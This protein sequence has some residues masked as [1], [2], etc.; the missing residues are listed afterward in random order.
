M[1]DATRKLIDQSPHRSNFLSSSRMHHACALQ[2][3]H[4]VQLYLSCLD[5]NLQ[6][7]DSEGNTCLHYV[8][9]TGNCEIAD[10][11]MNAAE[12]M[13]LRLDRYVN[14]EGQ[15]KHFSSIHST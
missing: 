3:I 2:R 8:A 10:L 13:N 5:F 15:S 12:K 7:K 14:R 11:L 6:A 4:L 1:Q 9:I